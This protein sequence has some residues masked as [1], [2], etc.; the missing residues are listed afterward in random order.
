MTK[1]TLGQTL[2]RMVSVV[3]AF[4]G[5]SFAGESDHRPR[6]LAEIKR[7]IRELA[8]VKTPN[9]AQQVCFPEH[10]LRARRMRCAPLCRPA[11]IRDPPVR[12]RALA[13]R[14]CFSTD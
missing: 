9:D 3:G 8:M 10:P 7:R 4:V 12:H 14:S 13:S 11:A 1:A 5:K 2:A 6:Q